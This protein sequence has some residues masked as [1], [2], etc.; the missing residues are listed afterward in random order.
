M[1]DLIATTAEILDEQ[2]PVI[3]R[4][5]VKIL[6]TYQV[7]AEDLEGAMAAARKPL[8]NPLH[9]DITYLVETK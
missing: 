9:C 6:T 2:A 4:Y 1:D 5:F 7:Y 8:T 3:K